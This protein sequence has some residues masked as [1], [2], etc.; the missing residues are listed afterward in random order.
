MSSPIIPT[1]YQEW[2]HCITVECGIA[3]TKDFIESR[4][5][6]L[7]SESDE[8]TRQFTAKF[9]PAYKAQVL[10]WFKQARASV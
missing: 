1:T 6:A 2:Q 3:L 5:T 8:H 10:T 4:I 9:G 7:Q